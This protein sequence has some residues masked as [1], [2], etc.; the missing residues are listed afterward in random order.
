MILWDLYVELLREAIFAYSQACGGNLATGIIGVT[1]LFRMAIFPLTLRIAKATAKHHEAMSKLK[2][3]LERLQARFRD[4]PEKLAEQSQRLF[5]QHGVSPIPMK[6]CLGMLVQLPLLLGLFNAVRGIAALGG[7]FLWIPNIARP[8]GVLTILVAGLTYA[9]VA[10]GSQ[11]ADQNKTIMLLIPTIVTI[12]V[13]WTLPAGI[14]LYWG[15]T[16][17]VGTFQ[18]VIVR[19]QTPRTV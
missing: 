16:S 8:D 13:L 10:L 3:E 17:L 6:G 15:V 7:R 9:S 2:P 4:K 18:S 1:F 11:A 12:F 19:S 5:R 14:G